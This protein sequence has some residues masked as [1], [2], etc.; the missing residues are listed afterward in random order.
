MPECNN[1][2]SFITTKFAR[3]FGDNRHS[4]DGCVS[5][6]TAAELTAGE[7][8]V[9]GGPFRVPDPKRGGSP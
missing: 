9:A 8:S 3:V 6:L 1:C 2:G 4:V 7:A 5:C